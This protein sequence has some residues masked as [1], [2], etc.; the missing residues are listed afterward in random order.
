MKFHMVDIIQRD[1]AD[2]THVERKTAGFNDLNGDAEAGA[3]AQHGTH[4]GSYIRLIER[5]FHRSKYASS[6]S[7]GIAPGFL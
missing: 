7:R 4:I 6:A 2:K 3:K 1:T 5:D